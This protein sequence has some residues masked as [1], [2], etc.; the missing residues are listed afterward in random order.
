MLIPAQLKKY[1]KFLLNNL[2]VRTGRVT[3]WKVG[4]DAFLVLGYEGKDKM[5]TD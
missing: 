4:K 2:S 1:V 5:H 3:S